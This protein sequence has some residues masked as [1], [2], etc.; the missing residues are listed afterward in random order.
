MYTP[1]LTTANPQLASSQA[2][3]ATA[4]ANTAFSLED[5]V[6]DVAGA[7]P[8]SGLRLAGGQTLLLPTPANAALLAQ[9]A[10]KLLRDKMQAAGMALT[11]DFSLQ[12]RGQP[13][14]FKLAG[15][16]QDAAAIEAMINDDPELSRALHN[17][18]GLA[19]HLPA[20]AAASAFNEALQSA[21]SDAQRQ[22]L[23]Q[24]YQAS[25]T[26]M[27]SD[28]RLNMQGGQLS[29]WVNGEQQTG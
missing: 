14:T 20:L 28:V 3:T 19:S 25:I 1:P 7:T 17:A 12:A 16:R 10:G 22:A 13:A 29:V 18:S 24:Y 15:E 26:S 5:T 2:G 6:V 21:G 9:Q 27:R 11:P 4:R 23:W 8:R